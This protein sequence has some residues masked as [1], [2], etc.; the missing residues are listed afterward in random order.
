MCKQIKQVTCIF[1]QSI[2]T[3][4]D[5]S[6]ASDCSWMKP[7]VTTSQPVELEPLSEIYESFAERIQMNF[8]TYFDDK[9]FIMTR[10]RLHQANQRNGH[11]QVNQSY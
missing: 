1:T 6:S 11:V 3:E 4:N 7:D 5:K 9:L 10:W 8:L 2:L